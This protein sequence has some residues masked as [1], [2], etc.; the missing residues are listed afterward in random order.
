MCLMLIFFNSLWLF[1]SSIS[2]SPIMSKTT[3]KQSSAASSEAAELKLKNEIMKVLLDRNVDIKTAD[4][5]SDIYSAIP[6]SIRSIIMDI[7][8]IESRYDSTAVSKTGDFGLGQI[9]IKVWKEPKDSL[10][11][12][13]YNTQS[14]IDK[15]IKALAL[16][17]N[18]KYVALSFYNGC[19]AYVKQ[20][21]KLWNEK[22]DVEQIRTLRRS[23]L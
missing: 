13:D 4:R 8:Y 7:H 5:L 19:S 23:C 22:I 21:E 16:S 9:N 3:A 17:R 12:A 18:N 11:C 6:D 15:Y 20:Y 2:N 1:S 10:L 14:T